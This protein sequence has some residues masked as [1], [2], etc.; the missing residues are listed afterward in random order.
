MVAQESFYGVRAS[1]AGA[2]RDGDEAHVVNLSLL[3]VSQ[4][5]L[6]WLQ[7]Q[8]GLGEVQVLSR[9]YGNC[10]ISAAA[11]PN[12]WWVQFFNSEDTL[13][14]NTIEVVRVPRVACAAAEDFQ[15]SAA[16][17]ADILSAYH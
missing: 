7:Q 2:Y 13:I 6:A 17:L 8:L 14:L 12:C 1:V 15:D 5:E 11:W 3:P 16:R 10:R 9:G 4:Q